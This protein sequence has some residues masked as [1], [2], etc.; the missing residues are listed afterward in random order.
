MRS[1]PVILGSAALLSLAPASNASAETREEYLARLKDICEVECLQPRQ[2][3]RTARKRGDDQSS[4]MAL[5]MDV[6]AVRRVGDKIQLHNI[7]LETS[8]FE[9]LDALGSAGIDTSQ[10]GGIGGLPRSQN[11]RTHPNVVV[12]E[13]DQQ[14]LFDLLNP[15][16]PE[17]QRAAL[18][19]GDAD[20]IVEGDSERTFK[21]P[22]LAALEAAILNRRIV[23]RGQ[24]RLEVGIVGARRDRRRKQAILEVD[25][26]AEMALL[27]RYDDD[28][29][30][31]AEDLPWLDVSAADAD[32]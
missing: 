26:A 8:H 5:I 27:P 2:F 23:V 31:R 22:T 20:I 12:I 21:R 9:V 10:R 29:N 6:R 25:N 24:H 17:V 3:Q 11:P 16:S 32:E 1:V 30:P 18:A 19:T 4:D 15:I 28:G 14:T 7:N 13:M